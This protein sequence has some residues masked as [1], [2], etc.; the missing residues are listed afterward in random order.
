MKKR[1]QKK[2]IQVSLFLKPKKLAVGC[3]FMHTYARLLFFSLYDLF[4][5]RNLAKVNRFTRSQL[6]KPKDFCIKKYYAATNGF[7]LLFV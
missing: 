2:W 7:S 3:F 5:V 1:M 6:I 4:A